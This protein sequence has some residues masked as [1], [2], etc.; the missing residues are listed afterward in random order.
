MNC[1][2]IVDY[3]VL[4]CLCIV[5]KHAFSHQPIYSLVI[6]VSGEEGQC[7][8]ASCWLLSSRNNTSNCKSYDV[9]WNWVFANVVLKSFILLSW[10]VIFFFAFALTNKTPQDSQPLIIWQPPMFLSLYV[11]INLFPLF[12]WN[13]ADLIVIYLHILSFVHKHLLYACTHHVAF[14]C[15]RMPLLWWLFPVR[16]AGNGT[17]GERRFGLIRE[18][19]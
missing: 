16:F 13:E 1:C 2:F 14:K 12:T 8:N 18:A 4:T 9:Q 15:K 3:M 17:R 5:L 11:C 19:N 6:A 10:P 7:C